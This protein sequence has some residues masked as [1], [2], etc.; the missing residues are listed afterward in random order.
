M[1]TKTQFKRDAFAA[2]HSAAGGLH[3]A[4]TI[5]KATLRDFDETCLAALAAIALRRSLLG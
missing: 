5:D 1:A 3:P 2:I 4:G